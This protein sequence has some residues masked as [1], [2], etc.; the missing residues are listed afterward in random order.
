M[1]VLR[2]KAGESVSGTKLAGDLGVSRVAVWKAI[3]ALSTAGYPIETQASGYA[4][5]PQSPGDFL[6]PW[7]F[8]EKEAAFRYF[9]N[10]GSTMD[11]AKEYAKQGL[12]GGTIIVA[13]KQNAGRGRSGSTWSSRQGGVFCTIL[14]RPMLSLADYFLSDMLCQIAIARALR[15]FCGKPALLRW[16]NDV[17]VNNRKIAGVMTELEGEGNTINW[18]ATGFGVNVNNQVPLGK[19]ITCAEIAGHTLSRREI[20]LKIID[21]LEQAK[22]RTSSV[23]AYTQGNRLLA[24]EWN[25][26]ADGIGSKAVVVASGWETDTKGRV[27]AKG[28]FAGLDPA[29]RCIIKSDNGKGALYFNPGPV[30]VLLGSRG[31]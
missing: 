5:N 26:M 22:K 30:S 6:Y 9:D 14:D 10:T 28:I 27:L 19:A 13:D 2:E 4:L 24:A 15:F 3:Q 1:A 18:L 17:Y 16:P 12:P 25:S 23:T 8:G 7:E 31:E 11:R 20:L 29:G 21:E